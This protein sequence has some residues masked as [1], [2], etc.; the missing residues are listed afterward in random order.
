MEMVT[1]LRFLLSAPAGERIPDSK[2][3]ELKMVLIGE[4]ARRHVVSMPKV[5]IPRKKEDLIFCLSFVRSKV[6]PILR[7]YCYQHPWQP[8]SMATQF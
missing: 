8:A 3:N 4:E 1:H 2:W 7:D 6:D 5:E